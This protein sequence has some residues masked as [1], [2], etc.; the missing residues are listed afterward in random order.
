MADVS[1]RHPDITNSRLSEW[2]K[3]DACSKGEEFVKSEGDQYLPKPS[4]FANQED[5]GK[6]A[7]SAY[8]K[9]ASFPEIFE[10]TVS[11]MVGMIHDKG[12]TIELPD[13]LQ[14][15][16]GNDAPLDDFHRMI[17]RGLLTYGRYGVLP[18]APSDGGKVFLTGYA[19][20]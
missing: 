18:D 17:T 14:E 11:S 5:G 10:P 13:S 16:L 6:A 12:I 7:Y 1:T 15:I 3:V 9:R 20:V 2:T 19:G 4:G 8:K